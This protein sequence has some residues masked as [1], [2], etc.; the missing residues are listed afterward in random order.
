MTFFEKTKTGRLK[1]PKSFKQTTERDPLLNW[2]GY[3]LAKIGD[4]VHAGSGVSAGTVGRICSIKSLPI[5]NG[6]DMV[7]AE[8]ECLDG[9]IQSPWLDQAIVLDY[10]AIQEVKDFYIS[11]GRPERIKVRW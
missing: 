8:V 2:Y 10:S 6:P 3:P 11:N 1:L 7:Y 9:K 5:V 4:Y